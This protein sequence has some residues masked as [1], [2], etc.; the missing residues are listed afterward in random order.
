MVVRDWISS[1][2]KNSII[3]K[4]IY[5]GYFLGKTNQNPGKCDS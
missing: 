4:R 1:K 2:I 3:I 5:N